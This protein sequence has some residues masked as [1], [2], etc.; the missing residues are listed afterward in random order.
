MAVYYGADVE[1]FPY[2]DPG[3]GDTPI[4][5]GDSRL[6]RGRSSAVGLLADLPRDRGFV[7]GV[8]S[9]AQQICGLSRITHGGKPHAHLQQTSGQTAVRYTNVVRASS[10]ATTSR[11][12]LWRAV[13]NERPMRFI[14]EPNEPSRN[15]RLSLTRRCAW[16]SHSLPVGVTARLVVRSLVAG[17]VVGRGRERLSPS[18]SSG[19]VA[20]RMVC[21]SMEY[22]LANRQ[23][24]QNL[25]GARVPSPAS[26]A[27]TSIL[28]DSASGA[29]A[30]CWPARASCCA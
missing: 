13:R 10:R 23:V 19:Q 25:R 22:Q 12:W 3:S 24:S 18:T 5:T 17:S 30:V 8:P 20:T 11:A 16:A 6:H 29:A 4:G 28:C 26:V 9:H 15:R 2:G 21:R 7:R 1:G 14:E 27:R